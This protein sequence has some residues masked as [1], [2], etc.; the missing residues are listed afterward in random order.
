MRDS[1]KLRHRKHGIPLCQLAVTAGK[2]YPTGSIRKPSFTGPC[3]YAD[4]H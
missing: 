2:G 3:M 4:G 1:D